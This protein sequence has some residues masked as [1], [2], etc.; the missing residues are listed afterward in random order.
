MSEYFP[1][2]ESQISTLSR[3]LVWKYRMNLSIL[4][5]RPAWLPSSPFSTSSG[6]LVK[7]LLSSSSTASGSSFLAISPSTSFGE[8]TRSDPFSSFTAW[9]ER[10]SCP[11]GTRGNTGTT[12]SASPEAAAPGSDDDK[13]PGTAGGSFTAAGA[14][15]GTPAGPHAG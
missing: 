8:R 5:I 6:A 2:R 1:E 4:L 11:S 9:E 3:P 12:A 10:A 7:N 14:N 13:G 15:G